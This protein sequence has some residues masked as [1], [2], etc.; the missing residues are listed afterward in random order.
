MVVGYGG[1]RGL[2]AWARSWFLEVTRPRPFVGVV[3]DS[4][5][6]RHFCGAARPVSVAAT[7]PALPSIPGSSPRPRTSARSRLLGHLPSRRTASRPPPAAPPRSGGCPAG[8]EHFVRDQALGDFPQ[9]D[10]RFLVVLFRQQRLDAAVHLPGA[11]RG[12]HDQF[13]AVAHMF[14]TVFNGDSGHGVRYKLFQ[15][16]GS[17]PAVNDLRQQFGDQRAVVGTLEPTPPRVS[18]GRSPGGPRRPP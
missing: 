13:E 9:C 1:L 15:L 14:K 18:P 8:L 2:F 4:A 5:V 16:V 12:A 6:V 17:L 7:R 3:V 10:H 11:A